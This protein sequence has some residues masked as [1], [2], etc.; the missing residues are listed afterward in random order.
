M[1]DKKIKTKTVQQDDIFQEGAKE[2]ASMKL[3]K[4]VEFK[5]V[6]KP[7]AKELPID[8]MKGVSVKNW[9]GLS[10]KMIN[11]YAERMDQI[12]ETLPPRDFIKVYLQMLEYA[13]PKITRTVGGN[14]DEKDNRIEVVIKKVG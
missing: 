10:T 2:S 12:M 11:E 4:N 6:P 7:A 14:I 8:Y 13:V 9:K 1:K 3:L 5:E